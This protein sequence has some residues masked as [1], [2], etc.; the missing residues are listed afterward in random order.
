MDGHPSSP[1][2]YLWGLGL[3]MSTGVC[4]GVRRTD[5]GLLEHAAGGIDAVL[6]WKGATGRIDAGGGAILLLAEGNSVL[7]L[8]LWLLLL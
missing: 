1:R 8:L 6:W 2:T 5:L 4:S 3:R 7:L